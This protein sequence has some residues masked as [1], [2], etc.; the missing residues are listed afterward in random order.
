MRQSNFG[1]IYKLVTNDILM[2]TMEMNPGQG[3]HAG[4][5]DGGFVTDERAV[6]GFATSWENEV[7]EIT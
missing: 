1:N 4:S 7:G 6:A 3:N 2:Q 5:A